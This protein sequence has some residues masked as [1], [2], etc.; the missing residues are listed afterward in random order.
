MTYNLLFVRKERSGTT[1]VFADGHGNYF[2]RGGEVFRAH[3]RENV[4][5]VLTP[6]H[7]LG[8]Q[9]TAKINK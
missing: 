4:E 8:C 2:C 5:S 6:N 3:R 9:P 7:I 1:L